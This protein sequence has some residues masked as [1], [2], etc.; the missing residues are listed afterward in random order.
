MSATPTVIKRLMRTKEAAEYLCI[1]EWKLRRL[2][3][4]DI[5][6]IVQDQKGAPFLLDVYDL[7][8]YV[9]SNKHRISDSDGWEP[10]PVPSTTHEET[11]R[12][13]RLK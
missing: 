7:D 1:S 9:E 4:D 3:Q 11:P 8:A 13:K 12:L 10:S 2:I 5:I 6:P